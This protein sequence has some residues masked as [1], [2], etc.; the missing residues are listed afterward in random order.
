[1]KYVFEFMKFVGGFLFILVIA[2][3]FLQFASA[4]LA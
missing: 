4:H 3:M 2:L 1:M